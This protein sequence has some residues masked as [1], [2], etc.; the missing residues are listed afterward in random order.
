M[1]RGKDH[2]TDK[3]FVAIAWLMALGMLFLVFEKLKLLS[4]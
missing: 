3:I 2:I 4:H 1:F